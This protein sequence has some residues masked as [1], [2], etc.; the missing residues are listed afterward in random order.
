MNIREF[1]EETLVSIAGGIEGANKRVLGKKPAKAEDAAFRISPEGE[2]AYIE[3]D[4]AVTA[5]VKKGKAAKAGVGIS[6]VNMGASKG[7]E[8]SDESISRIKFKVNARKY[9]E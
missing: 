9:L 3:F 7:E 8:S 2:A 6:V 5:G 4:I 1:V